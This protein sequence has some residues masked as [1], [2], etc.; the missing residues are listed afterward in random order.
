MID[1]NAVRNL[2]RGEMVFLNVFT[3]ICLFPSSCIKQVEVTRYE[4]TY[5]VRICYISLKTQKEF[6]HVFSFY[7]CGEEQEALHL[8]ELLSS[9][10]TSFPVV[11]DTIE[12]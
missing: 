5:A 7:R 12:I 8:I 6:S 2:S 1:I 3:H 11:G 9:H 4:R 10:Y